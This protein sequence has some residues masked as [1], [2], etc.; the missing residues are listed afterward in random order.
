MLEVIGLFGA[1]RCM[2]AS[3]WHG[4]GP[5][6]NSDNADAD[7]LSMREL[8]VRFRKWVAHLTAAQRGRLFEGSAKEFYRLAP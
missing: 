1:K 8:Y 5:T 6:S 2:F 3:N 4:S 7:D